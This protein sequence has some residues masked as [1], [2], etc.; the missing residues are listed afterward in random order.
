MHKS[1]SGGGRPVFPLVTLIAP[2]YNEEDNLP[3]LAEEVRR[4]MEG[5]ARPWR[6]LLV[7][8]GSTDQ[9]LAVIRGLAKADARFL[10][11]ALQT[12]SGQSAALAAAFSRAPGDIFVTLDADLQNDPADIPALLDLLDQ[13]YDLAAGF[14]LQRRDS[15]S[16]RLASRLA[17][18]ARRLFLKDGIRD[19]GCSLKA[20]R[21]PLVRDLPVFRGMHRFLPALMLLRGAALVQTPVNH[22]PRRLG[23]SKYRVLDRLWPG[24]FDLMG[25]CWLRRR[26]ASYS[27][28]EDG[29]GQPDCDSG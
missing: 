7:D 29:L 5:Q 15:L 10:Y 27:L 4:A 17:N 13:G 23:L 11:L 3:I 22:R 24:L 2:V 9:S 1:P 14:R 6:L 25:V 16:R 18:A 12:N 19:T 26:R 8:D 21:A 20:M 28:K